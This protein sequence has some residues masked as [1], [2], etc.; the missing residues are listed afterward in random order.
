[1]AYPF[2]DD[3]QLV[4][5]LRRGDEQ[6]F[7][8]IYRRYW[9]ILYT[10][11]RQ[12][13]YSSEVIEELLQDLFTRLWE[14]RAESAILHLKSYLFSS[15]K[16]AIV[17]HV[18]SKMVQERYVAQV[19]AQ[20]SD[21]DYVTEETLRVGDLMH[22]LEQSLAGLPDKTREVFRLNRLEQKSVREISLLMKM[23]E[24]TVEYHLTKAVR[25]LRLLLKPFLLLALLLLYC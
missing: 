5:F 18:K 25:A 24:R 6:A 13:V 19:L 14:R 15:L 10:T 7:A 17:D 3:E 4:L 11:A 16:Y 20:H 23:P 21:A 2:L 1:V 9:R 22:A 8:E 12:K